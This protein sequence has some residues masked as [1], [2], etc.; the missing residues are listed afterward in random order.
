MSQLPA[1]L[2][3]VAGGGHLPQKLLE[4]C[5]SKGVEAF[6]IAFD[7]QTDPRLVNG[8]DH[9][10]T[11]L[12]AAGQIIKSLRERGYQD[13]VL[14][15]HIKRPHLKELMP[16]LYTAGFLAKLGL[17]FMGDDNLLSAI[18]EELQKEGF[19]LHGIHELMGELLMPEGILGKIKPSKAHLADIAEGLKI[20]KAIGAL[21]IG[22]SIII[23][24]GV[25]LGVEGI[26]GTDELI[27]RCAEYR[28]T[29]SGGILVK[30]AKPQQDR[31]I[32][33]PTVGPV[34]MTLCSSFGF[35]GIA[36]EAGSALLVEMEE[37]IDIANQR[38][39]FFTGVREGV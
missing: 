16:D 12:G 9:I 4:F 36:V 5:D 21:D 3:I 14:I 33:L 24:D 38:G 13:L 20:A 2:G 10:V 19:T 18:H 11:R 22:Q 8:R 29:Q 28:R 15:G 1:K 7:G 35:D 30:A 39:M 32:D 17:R 23:Q 26:E 25:V 34:T 6:V 31:K 37:T 27:R